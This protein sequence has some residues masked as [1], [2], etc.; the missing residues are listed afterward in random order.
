MRSVKNSKAYGSGNKS[1]QTIS[2]D[3]DVLL[4]ISERARKQDIK[5]S[6]LVNLICR[7]VLFSDEE[8]YSELAKQA[9]MD[10]AQYQF[11]AERARDLKEREAAK[12]I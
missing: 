5:I 10:L 9:A 8:F 2:F 3:T 11:L 6:E 12:G 1:G 7:R 4:K